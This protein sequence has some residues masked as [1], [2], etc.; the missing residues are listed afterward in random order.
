MIKNNNSYSFQE[1]FLKYLLQ[2][3]EIRDVFTFEEI[4]YMFLLAINDYLDGKININTFSSIATQL[5]YTLK[6][7]S[8]FNIND[9]V[10]ITGN[11]L[12]IASELEWNINNNDKDKSDF[13]IEKLQ[14][15]LDEN[16][17]LLL[18]QDVK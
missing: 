13:L 18:N 8:R 5:Y 14:K 9:N 7:P 16:K 15:Y 2:V 17:H 10:T 4:K 12:D 3:F 11:I 1:A 6:K